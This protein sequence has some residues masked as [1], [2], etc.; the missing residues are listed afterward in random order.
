[1]AIIEDE[2][3]LLREWDLASGVRLAGAYSETLAAENRER[4]DLRQDSS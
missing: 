1:M 4:P 2:Q 3:I